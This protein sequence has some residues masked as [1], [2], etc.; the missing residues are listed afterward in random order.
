MTTAIAPPRIRTASRAR[1][2]PAAPEPVLPTPV[3][4]RKQDG[5]WFLDA[6][7]VILL[8][9]AVSG[10]WFAYFGFP[11]L[12]IGE[13][14]LL[15][16][17]LTVL[18]YPGMLAE[19]VRAPL[20]PLLAAFVL[21]NSFCLIP[22]ISEYGWDAMRDAAMWGYSI[23]ALVVYGL[24]VR[25]QEATGRFIA[26]YREFCVAFG[27]LF[28]VGVILVFFQSPLRFPL[29]RTSD[30]GVFVGGV[31]SYYM[32]VGSSHLVLWLTVAAGFYGLS[33]SRAASLATAGALALAT[34][35]GKK[36]GRALIISLALA[37]ALVTLTFL[38]AGGGLG[39]DT[40][41]SR[42]ILYN[43]SSIFAAAHENPLESESSDGTAR[44]RLMWWTTIID[45]TLYGEYFWMGR[46]YGRNI[47]VEDGYE[48]GELERGDRPLRS[49][50]SGHL[51]YLARSGVPGAILWVVLQL[52]WAARVLLYVRR[53][54][55]V[56]SPWQG[57]FAFLLCFWLALMTNAGFGV[58]LENPVGGIWSWTV[59]GV[60]LASMS[61]FEAE[62]RGKRM[63]SA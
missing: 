9:Y 17:L 7:S 46:G 45:N 15:L 48:S 24:L 33:G 55:R 21:W 5:K 43:F 2:I 35:L 60:G 51:N 22:Y 37:I 41:S 18:R 40:S 16:G 6:L 8:G 10:N 36:K 13:M 56:G 31:I 32:L 4:K 14:V 25:T 58:F 20:F 34:V 52:T 50:H 39:I 63:A 27:V 23:Y 59:F 57:R 30:T 44:W 54:G 47:A 1:R 61:A 62:M 38:G 11:P 12:Y 49:P 28:T 3:P 26:R 53:A 42:N 29:G 19:M